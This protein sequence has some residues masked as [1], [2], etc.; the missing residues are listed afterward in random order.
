MAVFTVPYTDQWKAC[1]PGSILWG[2]SCPWCAAWGTRTRPS[3]QQQP[4]GTSTKDI[5]QLLPSTFNYQ[6][7]LNLKELTRNLRVLLILNLNKAEKLTYLFLEANT[8]N[9]DI[10]IH[11]YS[12]TFLLCIICTKILM[13]NCSTVLGYIYTRTNCICKKIFRSI[14]FLSC[15]GHCNPA[16]NSVWF[17]YTQNMHLHTP[18]PYWPYFFRPS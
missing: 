12:Y 7:P 5:S 16:C 14:M 2:S 15:F 6:K 4:A 3:H 13:Y 1:Q 11:I 8:D 18:Y 9:S 10:S 17:Q